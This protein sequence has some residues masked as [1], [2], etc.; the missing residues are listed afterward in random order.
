MKIVVHQLAKADLRKAR[1]WHNRRQ[2]G[3]GLKLLEDVQSALSRIDRDP[4]IGMRYLNTAF[5]FHRTHKF[6][7]VIY[8]LVS[9]DHVCVMAIAHGRQRQGYWTRRKPE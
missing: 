4:K 7:Y 1:L 8:Y 5:R 6:P 9:A 2:A 3:L